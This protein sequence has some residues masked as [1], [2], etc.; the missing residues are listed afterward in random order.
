MFVISVRLLPQSSR[1]DYWQARSITRTTSLASVISRLSHVVPRGL[2]WRGFTLLEKPRS[3]A[4][5]ACQYGCHDN[6]RYGINRSRLGWSGLS[7]ILLAVGDRWPSWCPLAR[8]LNVKYL[9]KLP[10]VVWAAHLW[11]SVYLMIDRPVFKRW[12]RIMILSACIDVYIHFIMR[13]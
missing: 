6:D 8:A 3:D 5:R 2:F 10:R 13:I 4:P 1:V 9:T 11:M 7:F 12:Q